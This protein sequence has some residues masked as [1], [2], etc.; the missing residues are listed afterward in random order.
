M[1]EKKMKSR[2]VGKPSQATQ[3]AYEEEGLDEEDSEEAMMP[4]EEA[5]TGL[6]ARRS[7]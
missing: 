1:L 5:P 4:T 7:K 3:D 6:I 2:K